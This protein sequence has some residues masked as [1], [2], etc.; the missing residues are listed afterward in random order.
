MAR[1]GGG[2]R[3]ESTAR[4]AGGFWGVAG[5]RGCLEGEGGP[6]RAYADRPRLLNCTQP[7]WLFLSNAYA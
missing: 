5:E 1:G 2:G 7:S 6:D 3:N 4:E